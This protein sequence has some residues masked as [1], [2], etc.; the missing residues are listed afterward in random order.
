MATSKV[1]LVFEL[2]GGGITLGSL[3]SHQHYAPACKSPQSLISK[4]DTLQGPCSAL[5]YVHST[6][7]VHCDIK[8]SNI[9][10]EMLD[11]LRIRA[12]VTDFGLSRRVG[13][14]KR[15]GTLR[16]MAPEVARAEAFGTPA[17][18]FSLGRVVYYIFTGKKPFSGMSEAEFRARSKSD[19]SAMLDW[20]ADLAIPES[21][22]LAQRCMRVNPLDRPSIA[23]VLAEVLTWQDAM[24]VTVTEEEMSQEVSRTN[25]DTSR[26]Q[27]SL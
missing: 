11:G 27:L 16:W 18:I 9:L 15:A 6:K 19:S 7:C 5:S 12:K 22:L 17:D 21:R 25:K 10:L 13:D 20:P 8:P 24:S 14:T 1:Q 4:C 2:V 23:E 26:V 3:I